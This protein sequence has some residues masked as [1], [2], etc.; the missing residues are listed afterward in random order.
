MKTIRLLFRDKVDLLLLLT[1][2]AISVKNLINGGDLQPINYIFILYII[3]V[4]VRSASAFNLLNHNVTSLPL[5][6]KLK[7]H[8]VPGELKEVRRTTFGTIVY[9]IFWLGTLSILVFW[10]LS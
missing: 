4:M 2:I 1:I 6:W 7:L 10:V 3:G 9:L 5:R 8:P